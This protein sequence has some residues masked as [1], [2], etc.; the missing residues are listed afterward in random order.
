MQ[1]QLSECDK[2]NAVC[3]SCRGAQMRRR[4]LR[5]GGG[6][7]RARNAPHG[8]SGWQV[9]WWRGSAVWKSCLRR[10]REEVPLARLSLRGFSAAELPFESCGW[11]NDGVLCVAR[12]I[13]N[14]LRLHED[15]EENVNRDRTAGVLDD[16][17]DHGSP[18]CRFDISTRC[19]KPERCDLR[20]DPAL[21]IKTLENRD[22][23][24]TDLRV[25]LKDGARLLLASGASCGG[26][27][28]TQERPKRHHR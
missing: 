20:Y 12:L 5:W 14:N 23:S 3:R 4:R 2:T 16:V 11:V 6:G 19:R 18:P 26:R 21:T 28:C 10:E 17:T 25:A 13:S 22:I 7:V 9:S 24:L 15:D 27:I 8:T 1:D